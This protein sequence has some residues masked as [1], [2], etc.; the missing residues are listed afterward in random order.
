MLVDTWRVYGVVRLA[1][2]W[3]AKEIDG[4]QEEIRLVW[5][6]FGKKR[7]GESTHFAFMVGSPASLAK[8]LTTMG[9]QVGDHRR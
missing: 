8:L 6:S 9:V 5:D 3:V 7:R 1:R 2:R 4:K